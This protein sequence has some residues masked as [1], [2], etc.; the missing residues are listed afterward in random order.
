MLV[1]KTLRDLLA[2]F[3]SPDPT[4][5]GGSAAATASAIGASLL[6]MVAALPK[7]RS[8]AD[9]ERH[10]LDAARGRLAAVQERLTAAIDADT[11]A[12]DRVVAAYRL[13]K[14]AEA[15]QAARKSAIQAALRGATDVPLSVAATSVEGLEQ[16]VAIARH[17]HSAAASDVGVAVAL[18]AAGLHGARLNAEINV[19]S[20]VDAGY[21]DTVA[22]T[23]REL[24]GRAAHLAEAA[25]AELSNR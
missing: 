9:A 4:P 2:A 16:A 15:E 17:G 3:A 7:T 22:N 12:Y 11:A 20:I 21:R 8:G 5:G 25:Q 23:I 13:P 18:L 19:G 10:E 6:M 1:D 14:A 24:T